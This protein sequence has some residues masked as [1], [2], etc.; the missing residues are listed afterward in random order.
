MSQ[1]RMRLI[2]Q[3]V[4]ALSLSGAAVVADDKPSQLKGGEDFVKYCAVCHGLNGEGYG[5]LAESLVQP[6]ADL[7]T[8]SKNN[9]GEFPEE[10]VKKTIEYGGAI[11]GH[12]A[13]NMLAWGAFF[14]IEFDDEE[15]EERI[16]NLAVYIKSLQEKEQ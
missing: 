7:T 12:G 9:D 2:A 11:K 1:R 13:S 16:N 10:R 15:V 5:P 4:F 6:P 3:A 14:S 8:L